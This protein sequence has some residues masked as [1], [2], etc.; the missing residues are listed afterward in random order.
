[1]LGKTYVRKRIHVHDSNVIPTI[2]G[3]IYKRISETMNVEG[4]GM[5]RPETTDSD[6]WLP[7]QAG[8]RTGQW[9]MSEDTNGRPF[10]RCRLFYPSLQ[11]L[12]PLPPGC[13]AGR[14]LFLSSVQFKEN[15]CHDHVPIHSYE[16][17]SRRYPIPVYMTRPRD[18]RFHFIQMWHFDA[19]HNIAHL[20]I[21]LWIVFVTTNITRSIWM[22][23]LANV[24]RST[25]IW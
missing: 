1:M 17:A 2:S 19:R 3:Q 4:D 16:F 6:Y 20:T 9:N 21:V 18:L 10:V 11:T 5:K 12:R 23:R 8:D 25:W 22:L 15:A 13:A 14:S 7:E 24:I